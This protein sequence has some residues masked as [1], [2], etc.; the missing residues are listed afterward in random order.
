MTQANIKHA[1]TVTREQDFAAWYQEVIS[2]A[3]MAEESGVR[4][5]MVI[6]P[7][8]YGIWE[9]IQQVMDAAIKS[10]GVQNCYF[11]LFIPLSYFAKEAEH[12]DGFAKEM[13]VV[14]HHRLIADGKGGLVPDPEAKLEEPLIVR[15]TS[16]TV[17]GA[18]MARWVQS[19]RDLPLL[20]NQWANVVRWEMRTRMFLRTSEFLW[21]EGHTA[22]ADRDDAMKETLRALEMYRSFS[23]DVLAMPVVAGEKPENERFP[24]AVSTWSIEAMMQDGKAL[25]A[26]TS[27]YL[28]TGFAEAAGIQYQNKEGQQAHCHTTSWGVSTR[29]IG[30]VI[31]THGDD[32]GLRVPPRIAPHQIVILPMLRDDDGDEALL[33]YCEEIR[34]KVADLFAFREPVRVLLDKR[35][36]KATQKRWAWVKKGAPIILEVGGRDMASGMV[37][38]IRR[39]RLWNEAGK[40]NFEPHTR[41]GFT[42][43]APSLLEA[44]Q[45]SLHAE[46]TARRDANIVRGVDSLEALAAHFADGNKYP[47]WVEL[48]WSRPTG[49][50]LEGVVTKLKAL[51]LTI[52]NTPMDLP[53]PSGH[54]IFTGKPAVETIYVARAY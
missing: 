2:E 11:P 7:W 17:I 51:K 4:G 19:W 53:A 52:R 45:E 26:G 39:D 32:D 14:T 40:V 10:A 12:V 24:G 28:G 23:E 29:L 42:S 6:K 5:C 21:Q 33:E 9:R 34:E 13:A 31:M 41:E 48:G 1:L 49:E 25:Q 37:S 18:A 16:E 36:G 8:G 54:C 44:I 50:E 15:P 43:Q 30:G 47:G 20:T 3:D 27:H 35:P 22:H 38:M 46:A